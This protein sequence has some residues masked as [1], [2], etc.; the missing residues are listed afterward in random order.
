[1]TDA[2]ALEQQGSN[3]R[4]D[5][6]GL[7]LLGLF[8]GVFLATFLALL[9]YGILGSFMESRVAGDDVVLQPPPVNVDANIENE[10]SK[11]LAFSESPAPGDVR[12]PFIDRGGIA[13]AKAAGPGSS[14]AAV[15]SVNSTPGN[16]PGSGT[17]A[18]GSGANPA[19]PNT[20]A[21]AA[22]PPSPIEATK[23]RYE[24]WLERARFSPDAVLDPRVFSVEDLQPVGIVD[25]GNGVQEVLFYSE[26]LDKTLSFPVGTLFH[27]GWLSGLR[28]EGVVFSFNDSR[29]TVRM[30]SWVR[31]LRASS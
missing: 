19:Q 12:D 27:D 22:P 5:R 10:L 23:R 18:S 1:M 25:G 2:T 31:S 4:K 6:L 14:V 8:F 30:R 26:A 24:A 16:S 17:T 11:V 9:G 29:R 13:D 7:K 3:I 28:P 20:A 21:Q 15:T